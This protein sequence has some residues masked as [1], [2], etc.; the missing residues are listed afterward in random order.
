MT[1]PTPQQ[2]RLLAGPIEGRQMVEI[3]GLGQAVGLFQVQVQE[4]HLD[5]VAGRQA[6]GPVAPD[7]VGV[8]AGVVR[9][10]EVAPHSRVHFLAFSWARAGGRS[11]GERV[12]T[13]TLYSSR[14]GNRR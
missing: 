14:V 1:T 5:P 6:D 9:A 7:V 13:V 8:G 2:G 10:G 12:G 11:N 3:T 4:E